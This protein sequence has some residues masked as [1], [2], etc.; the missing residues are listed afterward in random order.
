MDHCKLLIIG[1]GAAGMSA[2]AAAW[3]SGIHDIVLVDSASAPGGILRQCSHPGFGR[4]AFGT[5]KTGPEYASF[6]FSTLQDT[7]VRLLSETEVLSVS[8]DRLAVL[9]SRTGLTELCF[10]RLILAA[11]CRERSIGSL[12]VAGTRPAGVFTAGQ[13]QELLNLRHRLPGSDI[14]ILGSGDLGMIMAYQLQQAGAHVIAVVEQED[15]YGGLARNY[16]RF[17]EPSGVPLLLRTTVTELF[18]SG[19]LTGV[20]LRQLDTGQQVCLSCDTLVTAV[21]LIPDRALVSDLGCPDWLSFAGNCHRVHDLVDS[22]VAEAAS[23]GRLAASAFAEEEL[24]PKAISDLCRHPK[25]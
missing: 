6:L 1:A 14:L 15:H 23:V 19:R 10:Q 17:L 8:G 24:D 16:H 13:V 3:E 22:A 9:S 18:G 5:E 12:P 4:A 2:A 21:G 25:Q 11:G 20:L 7:G